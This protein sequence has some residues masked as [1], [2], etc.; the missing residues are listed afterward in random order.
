M[1]KNWIEFLSSMI[2]IWSSFHIMLKFA[3]QSTVKALIGYF[4]YMFVVI[5]VLRIIALIIRNIIEKQKEKSV[6]IFE[7]KQKKAEF[8]SAPVLCASVDRIFYF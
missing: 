4:S 8:K 6:G 3:R 7:E 1:S 5:V 2:I